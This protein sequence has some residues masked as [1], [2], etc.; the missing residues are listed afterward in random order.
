M[1]NEIS[2]GLSHLHLYNETVWGTKPGSPN[3]VFVPCN[4]YGVAFAAENRKAN[5]YVGLFQRK[6]SKNFKGMPTGALA[7][8]LYGHHVN[9]DGVAGVDGSLA[10]YLLSW[11]FDN[12][13]SAWLPSKGAQW[14]EGPDTANREHNGLRVNSL[15]LS[16]GEDTGIV[17]AQFDLRG[18]TET[19]LV[20]APTIPTDMETLP[21]FEFADATLTVDSTDLEFSNFSLQLQNGLKPKYRANRNPSLLPRTQ[22]IL[23]FTFALVKNSDTYQAAVR[24]LTSMTEYDIQLSLQ[25]PHNG[26]GATGT[27]TTLEIDMPRCALVNPDDQRSIEE[28]TMTTINL[29][30]LKPD[31]AE[32][33]VILTWGLS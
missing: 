31:T 7:C 14:A 3:Y 22:R 28:L 4:D 16:G 11:A 29:D 2:G 9:W 23:S 15:T 18:K 13:G 17:A 5:P 27:T 21:E 33:D 26:T 30:V 24:T 32:N 19:A 20:T 10:E 12:P 25:A 6:H 8:S 1:A